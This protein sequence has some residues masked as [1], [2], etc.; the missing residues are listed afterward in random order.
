MKT[1]VLWTL[2][3]RLG[4]GH[5]EVVGVFS[6]WDKAEQARKDLLQNDPIRVGDYHIGNGHFLDCYQKNI[7]LQQEEK[8]R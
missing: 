2:T 4:N 5:S 1:K 3:D 7:S 8:S 6:T